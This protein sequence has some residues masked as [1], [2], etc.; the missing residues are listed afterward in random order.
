[1]AK[2]FGKCGWQYSPYKEGAK[3]KITFGFMDINEETALEVGI[4]YREKGS[5]NNIYFLL[6]YGKSEV[7]KRTELYKRLNQVVKATKESIGKHQAFYMTTT[8]QGYHPIMYYRGKNFAIEPMIDKKNKFSCIIKAYD[9]NQGSGFLAQ[10]V[11]Q[12]LDFLSVETNAIYRRP[13]KIHIEETIPFENE[14]YQEDDEFIDDLSLQDGFIVISREGKE[15]IEKITDIDQLSPELE[16]FLKACSHFHNGRAME[17][18][19][20]HRADGQLVSMHVGNKTELAT[21]LYL[22][23]LEVVTLIGF[24]EDKCNECGQPK[25]QIGRRVRQLTSRYLPK[26]LVKDFVDYYDKRSKYLHAGQKLVTETPTRSHIP[27]LDPDDNSG[28][29]YPYKIPLKNVGEYVSYCL[30]KFYKENLI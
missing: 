17:E 3:N 15:M 23:A 2:E 20:Y 24:K 12:L 26:H 25:F 28:C 11:T 21:T 19:L 30:R 9:V 8:I 5:I 27:L 1:M 22:S 10:K 16:L 6:N 14:I 29:D 4:T 7:E 18:Q 13:N